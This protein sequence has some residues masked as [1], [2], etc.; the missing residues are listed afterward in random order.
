MQNRRCDLIAKIL[1]RVGGLGADVP[2]SAF[3]HVHQVVHRATGAFPVT[4]V[5]QAPHQHHLADVG[6]ERPRFI[7]VASDFFLS[8]D[9][10]GQLIQP[11]FR[12]CVHGKHAQW[13]GCR[14]E[15]LQKR[16][17]RPSGN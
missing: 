10:A 13:D 6:I 14:E 2:F 9:E 16:R 7:A 3:Q 8:H 11:A 15:R 17:R 12:T 1:Y 5:V 4:P